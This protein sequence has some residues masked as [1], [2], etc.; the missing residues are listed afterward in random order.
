[1]VKK[2]AVLVASDRHVFAG[3]LN[4]DHPQAAELTEMQKSFSCGDLVQCASAAERACYV[5]TQ[6]GISLIV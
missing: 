5:H 1:M 2:T 6:A 4:A 3:L